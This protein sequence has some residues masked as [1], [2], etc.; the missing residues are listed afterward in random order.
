M[1]LNVLNAAEEQ[2]MRK[3]GVDSN[4]TNYHFAH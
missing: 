1:V 4:N 3:S 2:R